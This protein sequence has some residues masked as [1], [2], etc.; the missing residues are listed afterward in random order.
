MERVTVSVSQDKII[1]LRLRSI[2][3]L[4]ELVIPSLTEKE[5]KEKKSGSPTYL[6]MKEMRSLPM[7]GGEADLLRQTAL[8]PGI[9]TGADG[10]G[11]LHVRGGDVYKRQPQT[12]GISI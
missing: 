1:R 12:C 6:N 11:G 8:Q 4:P 5:A 10:L 9:H 7:P 2:S 3:V